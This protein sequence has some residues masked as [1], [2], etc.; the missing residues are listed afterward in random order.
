MPSREE[1]ASLVNSLLSNLPTANDLNVNTIL[2]ELAGKALSDSAFV[3]REAAR[4]AAK[5]GGAVLDQK[6]IEAALNSLP[7]D[8]KIENR[9]IGFAWGEN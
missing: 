1:V 4:L 8:Q 6:S 7:T 5:A 9:R 3:I 2:D